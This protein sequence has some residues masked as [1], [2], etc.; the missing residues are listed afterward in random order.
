MRDH[1]ENVLANKEFE[2]KQWQNYSTSK[3]NSG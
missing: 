3:S 1:K 2:L